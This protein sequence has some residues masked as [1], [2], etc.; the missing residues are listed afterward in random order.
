[1]LTIVSGVLALW[2]ASGKLRPPDACTTFAAPSNEE[3]HSS[4]PLSLNTPIK[5]EIQGGEVHAYS[6]A[7]NAHDY[8][9][10]LIVSQGVA[11]EITVSSAAGHIY[12]KRTSRRREPTPISVIVTE[13]GPLAISVRS[14]ESKEITGSYELKVREIRPANDSDERRVAAEDLFARAEDLRQQS[15][16][17]ANRNSLAL[18]EQAITLWRGSGDQKEVAHT[19]KHIGDVH[20]SLYEMKPA[21][22]FY[23][24]AL[25]LFRKLKDLRGEAETL[26]ET[27]YVYAN[28]DKQNAIQDHQRA[29]KIAKDE[30]D[31]VAEAQALNNMGEIKYWSGD[32][33]QALNLYR[34]A[35]AI[36]VEIKDRRGQAQSYTYLG[37]TCSDLGQTKESFDAYR[38]ALAL[39]KSLNDE[40]GKAVTLTAIGRLYSRVGESQAALNFFER[41]MPL[42]REIGNKVEEARV[43]TGEAYVYW[44]LGEDQKALDLYEQALK[45]FAE[46][47]YADGEAST[48]HSAGRVYYFA[49]NFEKALEYQRRALEICRRLGDRHLE[50]VV[51]IEIGRLNADS[52]D[53]AAAIRNFVLVRDYAHAQKDLRWEMEAWNLLGKSYEAR[54][55]KQALQCY[56]RALALSRAA[57]FKYGES[58]MLYQIARSQRDSGD[59]VAARKQIESAIDVIESLR[60]KVT[61]QDLRASYF[62]SVRQLYELYIDLLMELN[63]DNPHHDFDVQA[64]EA[65]ERGRARSLLEMLTA[66]RVGVHDKVEPQ[67]LERE[68]VLRAALTEKE[69]QLGAASGATGLADEVDEL[70]DRYEEAKAVVHDASLKHTDEARPTPLNLKEIREQVLSDDAALLVFSLGDK[71]SFLWLI[72]KNSFTSSELPGRG[73]IEAHAKEV[74]ELL[75]AP[76]PVEG[77]SFEARQKRL[78]AME[79][80]YWEKATSFSN[81]L[82]GPVAQNLGSARLLIVPDGELQYLPFNAL[83]IPFRNDRTP[84]LAEHEITLQPSASALSKLKH[85]SIQ[86]ADKGL[87]IFADPVFGPDDQRFAAIHKDAAPSYLAQDT[88][89]TQALRDVNSNWAN[90]SIPR[91]MASRDEADGIVAVIPTA[92]NLKAVDFEANKQRVMG[93][94]LSHYRLL[95][96]ATHGV[97]DNKNPELSGLVLSRIDENGRPKDAF[98]RLDD[99]YN[100]KLNSDLVVLSA[101]NS[102][103]GKDVRGEGIIGLVH[104]FMYAGSSRVVASLW[105]VDDDATAALMVN[106][107]KEMFRSKQSPAAALRTAQLAMWRQQ[108]WHAPYYWAAFVLQGD[109]EGTIQ[110]Q[111]K[112]PARRWKIVVGVGIVIALLVVFLLWKRSPYEP[113]YQRDKE[114][115]SGTEF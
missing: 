26:N 83:P 99:I 71:R 33:T 91:L 4:Q 18:Y 47:N 97:L 81:M 89:M 21:L 40:R 1:M 17:V 78:A 11:P 41:A 63:H 52:G 9:R 5:R 56:E 107:Y 60:T 28:L 105:K 88:Q 85:R 86:E 42:S 6:V 53:H 72:T 61:S 32:L 2:L 10:V 115:R 49:K 113:R 103:L 50:M 14:A 57:E 96:F 87:A 39:W 108:R 69:E 101:C 34:R 12:L 77:E 73:E 46:A 79:E 110:L 51:L 90:G 24:Q 80:Q 43:L 95:H 98:L 68:E 112:S 114:K 29:M 48:L 38:S 36:W 74:R 70:I 25:A 23:H 35:L 3:Q 8:V 58:A 94:N 55:Q 13:S 37:Y 54:G 7:V 27:S 92:E 16:A 31:R 45:L 62:A 102:G 19:L 20:Q 66:A 65:S 104:G 106:F 75:M 15:D 44:R 100:L 93:S 59:I 111:E 76:V 67:L 109:Y 82:L 64:F 22:S 84:L 30:N